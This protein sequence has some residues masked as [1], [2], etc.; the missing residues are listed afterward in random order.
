MAKY[1]VNV[2]CGDD[3]RGIIVIEWV[4]GSG[5]YLWVVGVARLGVRRNPSLPSPYT[6]QQLSIYE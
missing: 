4:G 1:C 5:P 6:Y 2:N 3:E